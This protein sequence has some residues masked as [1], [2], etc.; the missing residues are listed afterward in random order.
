MATKDSLTDAEF[1]AIKSREKLA[2]K[3]PWK[4]EYGYN[5]G[6]A[7]GFFYIP[8]HNGKAKVEML[9]DDAEF[10]A[11]AREDVPALIAEIERLKPILKAARAIKKTGIGND[12]YDHLSDLLDA[13]EAH[14]R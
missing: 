9:A 3:G 8:E 2:S 14:D 1:K 6:M 5:G 11:K 13:V 4:S 7:T 12:Y 10:C